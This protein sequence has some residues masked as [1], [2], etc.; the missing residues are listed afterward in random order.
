MKLGDCRSKETLVIK[1]KKF[2]PLVH[3]DLD[4]SPTDPKNNRDHLLN[5]TNHPMKYGDCMSKG[6]IVIE[7]KRFP[8][9]GA[10]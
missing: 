2:P 7:G 9:F 8:A 3:C 4:L 1:W 10:L 6:T 5:T